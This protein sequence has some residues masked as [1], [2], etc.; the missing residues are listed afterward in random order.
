MHKEDRVFNPNNQ[1]HEAKKVALNS[2]QRSTL[3]SILTSLSGDKKH[4]V[5]RAVDSKASIWLTV[6]PVSHHHFDLSP[7]EFR[8]ALALRYHHP[9]LTVPAEYDGCGEKLTF[10]HALECRLVTQRH[11]EMRGVLGDLALYLI[12]S[13][14]RMGIT[15][16]IVK[17]GP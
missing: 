9:F 2:S 16:W 17:L 15:R 8:D 5:K 10:K 3:V 6:I 7:T 14:F 12:L 1:I 11:N 13:C 4:A